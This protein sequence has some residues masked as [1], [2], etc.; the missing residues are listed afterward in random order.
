MTAPAQSTAWEAYRV[1]TDGLL[2]ALRGGAV[3]SGAV[4]SQ[5]GAVAARIERYSPLWGEHGPMLLAAL[6]CAMG[7]YR[8]GDRDE[9]TVLAHAMGDRLYLL[10][11]SPG[12]RRHP[13]DEP[14]PP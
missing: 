2:P 4:R 14:A 3:D 1:V 9:L 12:R 5:L 6:R 7:L 8:A 11:A 10:S 13:S